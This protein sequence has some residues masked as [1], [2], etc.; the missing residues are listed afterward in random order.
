MH[1][2]KYPWVH[3]V[4]I[5]SIIFQNNEELGRKGTC[6]RSLGV[7]GQAPRQECSFVK[8][9]PCLAKKLTKRIVTIIVLVIMTIMTR[10]NILEK[11]Y[12]NGICSKC[13]KPSF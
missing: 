7:L 6:T 13:K 3:I 5:P 11:K 2:K 4:N 10:L 9:I 12:A 8:P 1:C